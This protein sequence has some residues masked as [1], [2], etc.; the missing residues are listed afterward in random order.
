MGAVTILPDSVS[1]DSKKA[2][3]TFVV[4]ARNGC[5][6]RCPFCFVAR[7]KEA[8]IGDAE[9]LTADEYVRFLN[10]VAEHHAVV[11]VCIQGF[12]PLLP[13]AFPY[14]LKILTAAKQRELKTG[15][16]TN[17]TFL[18]D[19]IDEI[20]EL[21]PD[22]IVV[23][24]DSDSRDVHDSLRGVRGTWDRA[25]QGLQQALS[26]FSQFTEIGVGSV[27]MPNRREWLDGIPKFL[28]GIGVKNWAVT[29]LLNVGRESGGGLAGK[30]AST[31]DDLVHL[32]QES[33]EN[34]IAMAV[35]D[36]LGCLEAQSDEESR[37]KLQSLRVR[38]V[39]HKS[40][41]I[42]LSPNGHCAIG[43]D[44]LSQARSE[45]SRWVPGDLH[46]G[47]LV[48]ELKRDQMLLSS[49]SAS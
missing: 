3:V 42:R 26:E 9:V 13:E 15:F 41:I 12:E 18:G 22:K 6:L 35:D 43:P 17:G 45:G 49:R 28:S 27:L 40:S 10:E 46:A 25:I 33:R 21:Q 39:K 11:A 4:P 2:I 38:T 1:R 47:K 36:E 44:I 48:G 23:S 7:R 32:D 24:L 19:A 14:T 31:I 5:N 8:E 29:P 20:A 16:V 30:T 34:G 37:D